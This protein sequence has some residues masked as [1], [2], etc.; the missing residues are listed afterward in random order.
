LAPL[1]KGLV[2]FLLLLVNVPALYAANKSYCV[3]VNYSAVPTQLNYKKLTLLVN[4][5]TCSSVA[6]T[7]DGASVPATYVSSSGTALFTT[8]GSNIT[9]TAV[10]WT[11]GGTGAAT[12]ATLYNNYHWAYSLTFDDNRQ[13]QYDYG[14]TLLQQHNWRAAEAVVSTWA[15]TGGP[16]QYFMNW[17]ELQ[18]LRN[19]YGWDMMNHSNDHPNPLTCNGSATDIVPEVTQNQAT[20]LTKFPGYY[21]NQ[22]VFPYENSSANTCSG[23]PATFLLSAECGGGS[24]NYVDVA[25]PFQFQRGG[26][27]GTD[28]TAWKSLADSA[29]TNSRPT[30]L[31]EYTHSVS[32]GSGAAADAYSTNQATLGDL[33]NHLD[34]TYGA[35]GNGSMWFA[36]APEVRD[37]IFVR[38]NA[39]VTTCTSAPTPTPTATTTATRTNTP[40]NTPTAT[41][42]GTPSATRTGTATVTATLTPT[43]SLS[44]TPTLTASRTATATPTASRTAT[45]TATPTVTFTATRTATNTATLTSSSTP[46]AT[47]TDSFVN[48]PT[49]TD[50]PTRTATST[51]TS[52]ATMTVSNSP[53]LTASLTA[54]ASLT[55]SATPTLTASATPTSSFTASKT[56]TPSLTPTGTPTASPSASPTLTGTLSPTSTHTSTTTPSDTPTLTPTNMATAT[57][58]A[59]RTFTVTATSTPTSTATSSFTPTPTLTP[60]ATTS[61]TWTP[62]FTPSATASLTPS[63]TPSVTPTYTLPPTLTRTPTPP[64]NT[65]VIIY[66]NPVTGPT[67]NV[68]PPA[69]EGTQAVRVEIFTLAFRRVVDETFPAVPN[70]TAVAVE[71]KDRWGRPLAEGVYY[72]VVTVDGRRST[73]KLLIL[74]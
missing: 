18:T 27:F 31:V 1:K 49:P 28:D 9:V 59:S 55:P 6:V 45:S 63:L 56:P 17:T 37:Y 41:A 24:F 58:T 26:L 74:R 39:V 51:V 16:G 36:P 54:T 65:T 38:D 11:A 32:S 53:T 72:V 43:S 29:A 73:G 34:T 71:L 40:A 50:T 62:S 20:L 57:S 48:S 60:S 64:A 3:N 15:N 35:T 22:M 5:G 10:N 69:Y 23:Y 19:T 46:S 67:I 14:V 2:S 70:G 13:S 12:K 44:A 4:V 30:W 42:T 68:L 47:P 7:A 61:K 52:T 21:C 33:L 25:L 8:T 66:P